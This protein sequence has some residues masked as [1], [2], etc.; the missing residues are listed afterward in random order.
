M[1]GLIVVAG[2]LAASEDLPHYHRGKLAKYDL[3]P[4]SV[5]LS[6]KDEGRLRAGKA[7]MQAIV[8]EDGL[9]RRLVSVQDI[10]VPSSVRL[11]AFLPRPPPLF[12]RA[13]PALLTSRAAAQV[14]LGRIMDFN[15]YPEMVSGVEG[16]STYSNSLVNQET[17][18]RSVKST[19][20]IKALHMGLTY[21]IEHTYDPQMGCM[22]FC[23]DYDKRSDLDDSV[24]YW[25]VQPDGQRSCRVFYS[26]ECKL[27]GWVPP[28]VYNLLTKEALKKATVWVS[29]ESIKEWKEQRAG[30]ACWPLSCAV[31]P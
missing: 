5:L 24:G 29:E 8:A 7:V 17:G 28:P 12:R 30:D 16:C 14:V 11:P 23:L 27:R 22:T 20:S 18:I 9:T 1:F 10:P 15:K 21:Y 13:L 6:R 19:Y 2:G 3:G 26:C 4:P 25:F 31:L